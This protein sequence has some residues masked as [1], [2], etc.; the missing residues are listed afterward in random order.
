MTRQKSDTIKE[1]K[2]HIKKMQTLEFV[3]M[4]LV[5]D[6]IL[7]QFQ[8]TSKALQ[9]TKTNLQVCSDLYVSLS[10]HIQ[11]M[12]D[13]YDSFKEKA[14]TVLPPDVDYKS[15][16]TRKLIC[17]VQPNDGPSEIRAKNKN[18]FRVTTYYAMIDKLDTEMKKRRAVHKEV[19][20]LFAFLIDLNQPIDQCIIICQ[21]LA[22]SYPNDLGRKLVQ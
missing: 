5:W 10:D 20:S 4:L 2:S 7:E 15:S 1:A 8:T 19:S 16:S 11:C 3:I 17:K 6:F 12:R 13:K 14:R 18:D 9:S 22:A 21:E